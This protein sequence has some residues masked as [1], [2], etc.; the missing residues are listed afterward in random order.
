MIVVYFETR[1]VACHNF[2][3][4]ELCAIMKLVDVVHVAFT[5]F[6][7]QIVLRDGELTA[8]VNYEFELLSDCN[9]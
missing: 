6:A 1:L 5:V 8:F 7:L 4:L 2:E 3:V 9:V